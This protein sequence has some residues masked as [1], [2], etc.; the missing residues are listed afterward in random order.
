MV[1]ANV[2]GSEANPRHLRVRWVELSLPRSLNE[3]LGF[4]EGRFYIF[5]QRHTETFRRTPSLMYVAM[6][7][8][9]ASETLRARTTLSIS[10]LEPHA[11]QLSVCSIVTG[12]ECLISA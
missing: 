5:V 1:L 10:P 6:R 12:G 9:T 7:S 11:E 8:R 2:G 3:R 4:D